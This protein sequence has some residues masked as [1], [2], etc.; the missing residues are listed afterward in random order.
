VESLNRE[1]GVLTATNENLL[2]TIRK[3]ECEK[4]EMAEVRLL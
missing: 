4:L 1:I 3:N 2:E